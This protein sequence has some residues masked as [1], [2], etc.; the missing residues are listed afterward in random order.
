[1]LDE[2][3]EVKASLYR[4]IFK[5]QRSEF[6]EYT[7]KMLAS[8]NN[9]DPI[10]KLQSYALENW[11]AV[12]RSYHNKLLSSYSAEGHVS[13]VLSDRLSSRPMGWS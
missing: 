3:E 6:K 13:H 4:F 5:K 2:A 7:D 11:R 9:P 12:M 1:M 8:A 10:L